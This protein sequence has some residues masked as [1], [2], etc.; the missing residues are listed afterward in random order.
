[1]VEQRTRAY[2]ALG[3]NLDD[4][5]NHVRRAFDDLAVVPSTRLLACSSLYR[6]APMG[7]AGQPDYINAVAE[8]ETGL[9][10]LDLLDHL[11]AIERRHGRVRGA[12]RWGPRTLD[13][14]LLVYGDRQLHDARLTLPHPGIAERAFVLYPLA[15]IAA[16][17][18]IAGLGALPDLLAACPSAG[19]E[20]VAGHD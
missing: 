13:L 10:A 3:S 5:I 20:R 17:L 7:P 12:E 4:P 9:G 16:D 1:M 6:T 18:R 11:L 8:I 19:I 14:D 15:E 2:V